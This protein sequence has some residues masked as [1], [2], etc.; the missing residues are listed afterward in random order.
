LG[1]ML[2]GPNYR[3]RLPSAK[4]RK[5]GAV[6]ELLLCVGQDMLSWPRQISMGAFSPCLGPESM[7]PKFNL[8]LLIWAR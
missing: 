2:S 3:R 4:I 5:H 1:A 7:A 6:G 8:L